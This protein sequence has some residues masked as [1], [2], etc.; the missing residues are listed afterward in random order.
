MLPTVRL[1]APHFQTNT[2]AGAQMSSSYLHNM[3]TGRENDNCAGQKPAVTVALRCAPLCTRCKTG[4]KDFTVCLSAGPVSLQSW[5]SSDRLSPAAREQLRQQQVPN[6]KLTL[7][8]DMLAWILVFQFYFPMTVNCFIECSLSDQVP[9]LFS[10]ISVSE[11]WGGRCRGPTSGSRPFLWT[12]RLQRVHRS[13][14]PAKVNKIMCGDV[15]G[16]L[17]CVFYCVL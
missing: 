12:R 11:L 13:H 14:S 17:L 1:T 7:A 9:L 8:N 10:I 15:R 2:P 3:A 16:S 6:T 4:P 5:S